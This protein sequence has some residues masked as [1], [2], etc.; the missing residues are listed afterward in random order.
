MH[1]DYPTSDEVTLLVDNRFTM[2]VAASPTVD[3]ADA[4]AFLLVR[5]RGKD[6]C[7]GYCRPQADG[8]WHT[9]L[10]VT[11]DEI[12]ESDSMLIGDFDS[13]VDAVVRLWLVRNSYNFQATN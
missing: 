5:D 1:A 7:I 13:R 3:E 10:T 4:P 12:S 2:V 8:T 6:V 9:R 11:Y